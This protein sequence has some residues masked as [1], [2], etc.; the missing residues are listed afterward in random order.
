MGILALLTYD[1]GLR[2]LEWSILG[3]CLLLGISQPN[4][5]TG[6]SVVTFLT[7]ETA[8]L[9]I[10]QFIIT[11]YCTV[12]YGLKDRENRRS[13]R[14]AQ[15]RATRTGSL[16]GRL[17]P[18]IVWAYYVVALLSP[19]LKL[20]L[21]L[22]SILSGADSYMEALMVAEYI[23]QIL[24]SIHESLALI[25]VSVT[26]GSALLRPSAMSK[27]FRAE[28]SLALF[29]VAF[30]TPVCIILI[31]DASCYYAGEECWPDGA[32]FSPATDTVLQSLVVEYRSI[33]QTG[34]LLLAVVW[35][36]MKARRL[37][38][39]V[40]V[41]GKRNRKITWVI[42]MLAISTGLFWYVQHYVNSSTTLAASAVH[43]LFGAL[44]ATLWAILL[45]PVR[46][47]KRPKP[48]LEGP[49]ATV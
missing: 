26:F 42:V 45:A 38:R 43:L 29:L 34:L 1:E 8:L 30:S 44:D 32:W 47:I 23:V 16:F 48:S 3:H 33:V 20:A 2:S 36:Q 12:R 40:A 14:D 7:T 35:F 6:Y 15:R 37:A 25:A 41:K 21:P 46:T 18:K 13:H 28:L 5:S 27:V 39:R 19:V 22:Q 4:M 9:S 10:Y 11:L 17:F 24:Y 49:L 31:H